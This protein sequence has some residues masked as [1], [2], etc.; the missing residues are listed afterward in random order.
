MKLPASPVFETITPQA[1]EEME[2][3]LSLRE[4][5]FQKGQTILHQGETVREMGVVLTGAVYIESVDL[6]GGRAILGHVGPGQV[7]GETYALSQTPL[8]V[9]AVAAEDTSVLFLDL[10]K[11]LSPQHAGRPWQCAM[12]RNLTLIFAQ[13]NRALSSRIFCT[14]SKNIRGRLLCY[15]SAQS[16][17]AGSPSFSIPFDRQQ[18]ADYLN[19]DRSAL[20]KDLGRMKRDGLLDYRKNR[21]R[22]YALPEE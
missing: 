16:V 5:S 11:L 17:K 2:Q 8:M 19:V 20:S 14:S 7:F 10:G 21:F 6:W 13:K 12:L 9:A 3:L 1:W 4:R 15:L 18:L 22:L